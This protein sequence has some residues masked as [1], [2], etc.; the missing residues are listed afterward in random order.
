M[1]YEE[2]TFGR[3][4]SRL[5]S[6]CDEGQN[7]LHPRGGAYYMA[8]SSGALRQRLCGVGRIFSVHARQCVNA[9]AGNHDSGTAPVLSSSNN[10]HLQ[11]DLDYLSSSIPPGSEITSKK[12][13]KYVVNE[14]AIENFRQT[15]K[16]PKIIHDTQAFLRDH[17]QE[18]PQATISIEKKMRA[19]AGGQ[20]DV[21]SLGCL[22]KLVIPALKR[23]KPILVAAS[24]QKSPIISG[25]RTSTSS[26]R[27]NP[28]C[29]NSYASPQ[30]KR[31]NKPLWPLSRTQYTAQK[32]ENMNTE[33]FISGEEVR[34]Q[35]SMT[36][37]SS[38]FAST[39]A[40]VDSKSTIK[41]FSKTAKL[42]NSS[43]VSLPKLSSSTLLTKS[44]GEAVSSDAVLSHLSSDDLENITAHK[45]SDLQ[46]STAQNNFLTR[47]RSTK[48]TVHV[49]TAHRRTKAQISE[50]SATK[51][52]FG[53]ERSD[54]V[55]AL[56][57]S[58][59]SKAPATKLDA[60]IVEKLFPVST[61]CYADCGRVTNTLVTRA[62]VLR[63]HH[64]PRVNTTQDSSKGA[65]SENTKSKTTQKQL[66]HMETG[67]ATVAHDVMESTPLASSN[68]MIAPAKQALRLQRGK[69]EGKR[70]QSSEGTSY[71]GLLV[72]TDTDNSG[73]VPLQTSKMYESEESVNDEI[74]GTLFHPEPIRPATKSSVGVTSEE[75][76]I[77]AT[78][79][80]QVTGN[81]VEE[82]SITADS[83]FPST[84]S[85]T[86]KTSKTS[87]MLTTVPQAQKSTNLTWATPK[88]THSHYSE[89]TKLTRTSMNSADQEVTTETTT[90]AVTDHVSIQ[91]TQATLASTTTVAPSAVFRRTDNVELNKSVQ[92]S[93][94]TN[95]T[96]T[97]LQNINSTKEDK[98]YVSAHIYNVNNQYTKSYRAIPTEVG[99]ALA[100]QYS[101]THD[102]I[103]YSSQYTKTTL[104]LFI[105]SISKTT[106]LPTASSGD[107]DM[108]VSTSPS[109][110]LASALPR[111]T[112]ETLKAL[113]FL[114]VNCR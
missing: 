39:S 45:H 73:K 51:K 4:L 29:S 105:E 70:D 12:K 80:E 6:R 76:S 79:A 43:T 31:R 71:Q 18:T 106:L 10:N 88:G 49:T 101:V 24:L 27:N 74:L 65:I 100:A 16:M 22:Q 63:P 44:R 14:N 82:L 87:H 102:K 50:V 104:P 60:L 95:T 92:S 68:G 1:A 86:S 108:L 59:V 23:L 91:D 42:P 37:R 61:A 3:I 81:P 110:Q 84:E 40:A 109:P 89:Q 7:F 57:M 66:R 85:S 9:Q 77:E 5:R 34:A 52:T 21:S 33:T 41:K 64:N 93:V 67:F 30:D 38:V 26:A 94:A 107:V 58:M 36:T 97:L 20:S 55:A 112:S 62:S 90:P 69:L 46:S 83:V 2:Q 72:L 15:E 75:P 99:T 13:K 32:I 17:R 35:A 78:N 113:H 47:T 8:C 56:K 28:R 114:L 19:S 25:F 11:Q 54:S 111:Q 96:I 98:G 103:P 48:E 53:A